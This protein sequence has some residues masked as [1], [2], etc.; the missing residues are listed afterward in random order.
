MI[1]QLMQVEAASQTRLKTKVKTAQTAVSSYQS[2]NSKLLTLNS[3][4]DDLGQLP[5]WRA[6]KA[7]ASSSSVTATSTGGTNTA[8]GSTTFDVVEL[9]K[10]QVS[11]LSVDPTA[12]ITT[13]SSIRV[14]IGSADPVDI[15][16]GPDK[17]AAGVAAAINAK[18][19]AVKAGV[20]TTGGSQNILQ[21]SGTK[22]GSSNAFTVTGLNFGDPVVAATDAKLRVGALDGDGNLTAGSYEVTSATNT[23]T[24]LL[25]G[26]SVTVSKKETGVTVNAEADVSGIA[27]K[28]Q[29]LVDAA[30]AALTEVTAQTKYDPDTKTGSPLTGDFAVR[31]LSQTIMSA[32]SGGL[33]YAN[34][35]YVKPAAGSGLPEETETNRKN[36]VFGSLSRLGIQLDRSGQLT[37]D[38]AKF[39][40][41]YNADPTKIQQAGIG[42]ADNFEAMAT[43]QTT[44]IS[45]VINGRKTEIDS[46]NSQIANWDTRLAAKRESLQK[47]YTGLETALGKLKNQSNWLAGQLG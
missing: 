21:L 41:A 47:Q 43:K 45:A 5:T 38:A 46:M 16:L 14:Q 23:F 30:N 19:I 36:V 4:A 9:A 44:S 33:T 37:F 11:T 13:A 27:A 1:T 34:P 25:T 26:V 18:G 28:F 42:F 40:A 20:V 8:A 35:D 12:P 3:A 32:I 15:Q 39:T 2:V 10:A 31:Q 17:S 24:G 6:V 29:A 22:T 7:T